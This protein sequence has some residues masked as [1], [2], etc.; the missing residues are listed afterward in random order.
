MEGKEDSVRLKAVLIKRDVLEE[1]YGF[2]FTD[3][4]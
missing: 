2:K 4:E 3:L 1:R